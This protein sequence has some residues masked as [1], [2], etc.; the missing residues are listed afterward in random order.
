MTPKVV[1]MQVIPV[2]GHDSILDGHIQVPNKPG[3]GIEPD[4]VR[5]KAA[6]QLYLAHCL[7]ERNDSMGMQYFIPG[8]KFDPKRPCMVR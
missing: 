1:Q 7:G 5:I 2:V 3:L 4:M 8:W 6:H